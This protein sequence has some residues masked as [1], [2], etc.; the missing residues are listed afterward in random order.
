MAAEGATSD[1]VQVVALLG[2]AVVAVPIFRRAG[3][4]SV[5]GYLAA[6][7]VIGP[8]GFG[9]FTDS[10]VDPSHRRAWRGDAAVR[11]RPRNGAVAAVGVE[12]RD[13]RSRRCPGGCLRSAVD[14]HRHRL[15]F[16]EARRVRRRH[17]LRADVDGRRAADP[18]RAGRD[19][20]AGRAAGGFD[21]AARRSGHRAAACRR[22]RARCLRERWRDV[23]LAAAGDWCGSGGGAGCR[24][25]LAAQSA[26]PSA[27][28]REGARGHDG[29]GAAGGAGRCA[30]DAAR[31][32]VDG[33][34]RVPGRRAALGIELPPS[35]R[36]RH[37][38][39]PRAPSRPLL[40]WRRHVARSHAHSG[41]LAADPGAR[42]RVH[43]GQ[44]DRHLHRGAA[45]SVS[46][47]GKAFR[48]RR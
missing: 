26:V 4:G 3:L 13:L 17:G 19:L 46:R 31:R 42:R 33:H 27:R 34:G 48:A 41:E 10:T 12:A 18:R 44:G 2:A 45:L 29:G 40:P 32:A 30:D 15:R 16:R 43:D 47:T 14:R 28:Q 21:P 1:L 39:L 37:R 11:D 25:I 22:R 23:P 5:L 36:D 24:R 38:A 6:G 9:L 7:L 8:F 20:D 35:A